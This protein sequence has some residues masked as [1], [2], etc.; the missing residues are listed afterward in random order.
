MLWDYITV[1]SLYIKNHTDF[2]IGAY[3]DDKIE[4]KISNT[5]FTVY[6]GHPY[7]VVKHNN[8]NLYFTTSW[9]KVF[10]DSVNGVE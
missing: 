6:R 2:K 10:A 8:D 5:V 4:V 3:S 1:A 7:V 9:N